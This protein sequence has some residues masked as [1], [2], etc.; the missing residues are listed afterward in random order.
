MGALGIYRAYREGTLAPSVPRAS[1]QPNAIWGVNFPSERVLG[2]NSVLRGVFYIPFLVVFIVLRWLG[3]NSKELAKINRWAPVVIMAVV[4]FVVFAVALE[5]ILIFLAFTCKC[6]RREK[7][8][9]FGVLQEIVVQQFES[10]DG[11]SSGA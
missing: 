11:G 6:L 8:S 9:M 1:D 3:V 5:V 4:A 7:K 10:P 2:W